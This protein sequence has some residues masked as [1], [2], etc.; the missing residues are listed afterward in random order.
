MKKFLYLL[1]A[2]FS[3]GYIFAQPHLRVDSIS[4]I[5]LGPNDTAFE[6]ASYNVQIYISNLDSADFMDTLDVF[7]Q[8]SDTTFQRDTLFMDTVPVSIQAGNSNTLQRFNYQ[9]RPVHFDDGDN[10]VVVWPQTRS[11]APIT[12]DSITFNV[13]F[14]S[15]VM[16]VGDNP[17]QKLLTL[18]PNPSKDFL[19]LGTAK[20]VIIQ[21][22]RILDLTG[23]EI[24]RN[25]KCDTL[26]PTS[27]L[28]PGIYLVQVELNNGIRRTIRMVK[29]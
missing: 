17:V 10:I 9:L 22:V 23:K 27:G 3:S 18:H 14:Y 4:G 26:I 12:T 7:L 20:N 19:M 2:L 1:L 21:Q 15:L 6:A 25:T 28:S 11:V 24:I 16:D 8:V 29:E 5:P 13:F